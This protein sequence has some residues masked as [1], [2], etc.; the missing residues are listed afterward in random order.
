[1]Q[2]NVKQPGASV[3]PL[4]ASKFIQSETMTSQARSLMNSQYAVTPLFTAQ[5]C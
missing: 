4:N 1:M 3:V 5:T 2:K